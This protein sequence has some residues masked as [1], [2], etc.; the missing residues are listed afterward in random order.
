MLFM[1]RGDGIL[2]SWSRKTINYSSHCSNNNM[3]VLKKNVLK[4]LW[5][6][7]VIDIGLLRLFTILRVI[8]EV[9]KVVDISINRPSALPQVIT[10]VVDVGQV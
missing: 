6:R 8:V 3:K 9:V 4:C 5:V 7:K 2:G 1:I 10:E